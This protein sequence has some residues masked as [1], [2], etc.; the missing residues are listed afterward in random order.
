MNSIYSVAQSHEKLK[1]TYRESEKLKCT[2]WCHLHQIYDEINNKESELR[3][4]LETNIHTQLATG[5]RSNLVTFKPFISY[6]NEKKL[7]FFFVLFLFHG[8]CFSKEK[9]KKKTIFTMIQIR[10]R[11]SQTIKQRKKMY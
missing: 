11:T 6:S 2:F 1:R 5:D 7:F 4:A 9:E 8:N 10:V 3:Y